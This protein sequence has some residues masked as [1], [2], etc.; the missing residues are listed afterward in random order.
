M[1]IPASMPGGI[2]HGVS[3]LSHAERQAALQALSRVKNNPSRLGAVLAG[4]K[5]SATMIG[6]AHQPILGAAALVHGAGHDTFIGGARSSVSRS[7]GNDTVL[8][9]S[10]K[11]SMRAVS[12]T[13][14]LSHAG[15]SSD[16]INIAGNT[17]ASIKAMLPEEKAKTHTV[18]LSDKT[19]VTVTGLSNHD[20]TKLQH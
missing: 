9:G 15:L 18:T 12:S 20:I 17:A 5:H 7:I 3:H 19:K 13:P 11:S 4:V 1:P 10:A 8:S 16:T 14:G 6:G 2:H